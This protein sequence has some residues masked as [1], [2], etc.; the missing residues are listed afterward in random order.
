MAYSEW[1][2]YEINVAIAYGKSIIGI[3]PLGQERIP[4]K[5]QDNADVIVGWNS[6]SV[7]E[8]VRNLA[9]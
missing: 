1:I 5:I 2:D 3:K 6:S 7:V 9:L 8:A 4:T